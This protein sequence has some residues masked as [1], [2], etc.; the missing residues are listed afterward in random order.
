VQSIDNSTLPSYLTLIDNHTITLNLYIQPGSKVVS[1]SGRQGDA[2]KLKVSAPP[3][4][5]QANQAV[6]EFFQ[7]C[8]SL[9]KHQ[10]ELIRGTKSRFKRLKISSISLDLILKLTRID[11]YATQ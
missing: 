5:G 8:F 7:H 1:L 4:D 10:L 11:S 3:V 2:L 6:L 9:R